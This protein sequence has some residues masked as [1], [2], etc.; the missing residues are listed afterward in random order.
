MTKEGIVEDPKK[1]SSGVAQDGLPLLPGAED[2]FL[3]Q[4]V[5]FLGLSSQTKGEP[6]Q[7]VQVVEDA[8]PN[9]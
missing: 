6:I 3:C 5:G 7:P 2:G 9:R 8:I 1:P 4:V